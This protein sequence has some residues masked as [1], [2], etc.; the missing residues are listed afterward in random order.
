MAEVDGKPVGAVFGLPDYNPRIKAI[1]GRLFPFGFIK[2]LSKKRDLKRV[3]LIS[4]NVLPEYQKWGIGIVLLVSLIPRGLAMGME[5]AE[6]SWVS[7]ANTLARGSLEKGNAKLYKKY[8]M[9]DYAPTEHTAK[10]E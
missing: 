2:L 9:Y 4:T 7:E 5:E 10:V 1:D 3:R 8:R 6:F